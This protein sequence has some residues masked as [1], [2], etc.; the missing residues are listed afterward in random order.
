[1]PRPSEVAPIADTL[2]DVHIQELKKEGLIR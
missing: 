1:M 2:Y